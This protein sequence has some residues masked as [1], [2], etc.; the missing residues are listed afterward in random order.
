M[1]SKVMLRGNLWLCMTA[2]GI[3]SAVA[4]REAL[5]DWTRYPGCARSTAGFWIVGCDPATTSGRP[6]YHYE[7]TG[8][9]AKTQRAVDITV[10]ANN[11][12]PWVVDAR[13]RVFRSYGNGFAQFGGNNCGTTTPVCARHEYGQ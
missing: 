2:V 7:P 4:V 11:M 8:F 13:G 6:V 9:Q 1:R 3:V 12:E 10:D 5:A